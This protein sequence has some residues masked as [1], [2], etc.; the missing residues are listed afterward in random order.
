MIVLPLMST[1]LYEQS[2][3]VPELDPTRT[4][5]ITDVP[6]LLAFTEIERT[7]QESQALTAQLPSQ[8]GYHWTMRNPRAI[9]ANLIGSWPMSNQERR[10]LEFL[11]Q[12]AALP[13]REQWA[14]IE[15]LRNSLPYEPPAQLASTWLTMGTI[16][17]NTPSTLFDDEVARELFEDREWKT[18]HALANHPL[19][20]HE[21]A[22]QATLL[23]AI[24]DTQPDSVSY[25]KQIAISHIASGGRIVAIADR[26]FRQDP[27]VVTFLQKLGLRPQDVFMDGPAIARLDTL[28]DEIAA[29]SDIEL[30]LPVHLRGRIKDL[31]TLGAYK[32]EKMVR[33]WN[34]TPLDQAISIG[35]LRARLR[36]MAADIRKRQQAIRAQGE[37]QRD[38]RLAPLRLQRDELIAGLLAAQENNPTIHKA[39]TLFPT[40][41]PEGQ[42]LISQATPARLDL[43]GIRSVNPGETPTSY[44]ITPQAE[45]ELAEMILGHSI[46]DIPA[47]EIAIVG[48]GNLVGKP[49]LAYLK[50]L[51]VNVSKITVLDGEQQIKDWRYGNLGIQPMSLVFSNARAGNI[52]DPKYL[53]SGSQGYTLV[54][55]GGVVPETDPLT[56]KTTI[57]SNVRTD[58]LDPQGSVFVAR[59]GRVSS[60]IVTRSTHEAFRAQLREALTEQRRRQ[61]IGA[62]ISALVRRIGQSLRPAASSHP[63]PA[64]P[65]L[66][67]QPQ[68]TFMFPD[69]SSGNWYGL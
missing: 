12:G 13:R 56:G 53:K 30:Y 31:E 51:R 48:L 8:P 16:M 1:T 10:A 19:P 23:T 4:R 21:S 55:D 26:Q 65:S 24:P 43:D 67:P 37:Q 47:E 15:M 33:D 34:N 11:S 62:R 49:L 45:V 44:P 50:R 57:L 5:F 66:V 18:L 60:M 27:S 2:A 64:L 39:I 63:L 68:P 52:I 40:G 9:E 17:D 6:P 41:S 29:Q 69:G 42:T 58:R 32:I 46:K 38:A 36:T 14:A 25:W 54:I 35:E 28:A 7:W 59:P 61:R 3:A 22:P 20:S